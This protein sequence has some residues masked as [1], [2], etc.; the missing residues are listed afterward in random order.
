MRFIPPIT[1][2]KKAPYFTF[3]YMEHLIKS[4]VYHQTAAKNVCT[5]ARPLKRGGGAVAPPGGN[6][7]WA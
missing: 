7:Q 1:M 3:A 6:K 4:V 2:R 5:C